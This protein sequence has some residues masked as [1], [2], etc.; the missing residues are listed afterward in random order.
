MI[1]DL[2]S[3]LLQSQEILIALFCMFCDS[4]L[5]QEISSY[6]GIPEIPKDTKEF[7]AAV[8]ELRVR[9]E[10]GALILALHLH[11]QEAVAE[12]KRGANL[13]DNDRLAL[14][15]IVNEAA[16]ARQSL[17]DA[18][19]AQRLER[20]A[21]LAQKMNEQFR[22][23][24]QQEN[25]D[26]EFAEKLAGVKGVRAHPEQSIPATILAPAGSLASGSGT[27]AGV[28]PPRKVV[29]ERTAVEESS[30]IR[31]P[32]KGSAP[33]VETNNECNSCFESSPTIFELTCAHKFCLNCIAQLFR[34]A[35]KDNSLMPVHCCSRDIDPNLVD[36]VPPPP[37]AASFK[38]SLAEFQAV[39]KMYC[40]NA[41]CSTFIDLD[42]NLLGQVPGKNQFTC[43][44]CSTNLCKSCKCVWH[45]GFTC[46]QYQSLPDTN[47]NEGD[48]AALKTAA[49]EG[50]QKC[51]QCG[52]LV[53]LTEGCYHIT[54][55]CKHQFCY[56]CGVEWKKCECAH[57]HEENLVEDAQ[58]RM[59]RRI[60]RMG[61]VVTNE[62][63]DR[64]LRVLVED[65]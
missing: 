15:L 29:L 36:R 2:I 34:N 28:R 45:S 1:L 40:A 54:C 14:H 62:E 65:L 50:W 52:N 46:E 35:T 30:I 44:K 47:R 21:R 16:V 32:A 5:L 42:G 4:V 22:N 11:H 10:Q 55:R 60:E 3:E 58:R 24:W 57:W 26:F 63:H 6:L 17:Q 19:M 9:D 23:L 13:G 7:E 33:L 43:K 64:R 39:N 38:A 20:D 48:V 37:A 25:D 41:R 53:S 12:E 61:Q 18:L 59:N 56:L 8:Q 51:K 31:D 49:E 27:S